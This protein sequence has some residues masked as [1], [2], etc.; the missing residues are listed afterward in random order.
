MTARKAMLALAAGLVALSVGVGEVRAGGIVPLPATLDNFLVPPAANLGNF[1]IVGNLEFYDF[2]YTP[3][4]VV[5]GGPPPPPAASSVVVSPFTAVAGETGITF[6]GG[7]FAPAN[8]IY[9]YAITYKVTTTDGSLITD[10]YQSIVGGNF[11]GTGLVSAGE[12]ITDQKGNLLAHWESTLG[13]PVK[14][15]TWAG[16]NTIFV[17]KDILIVGGSVGATV[18][19]IHQG[20]STTMIPEPASM[21]L[22]G[23]GL[24]GLLSFRR[25]IKRVSVAKK[26]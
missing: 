14:S 12:T 22:L 19:I 17:S 24:S 3:T 8:T 26:T 18:S 7:F 10:G 16:V 1:A 5:P 2:T 23:I 21:A 20:F 9:D 6:T 25:F 15:A 4:N 11:G 13:E